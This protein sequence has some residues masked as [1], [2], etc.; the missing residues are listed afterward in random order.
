LNSGIGFIQ[1]YKAEKTISEMKSLLVPHVKVFRDDQLMEIDSTNLVPGDIV[2]VSEGDKLMADCRILHNNEIQANEA[3][4]TG[5]SF[6]Q[7][8]SSETL[9]LELELAN[10]ENMLYMG[11]SIIGGSGKAVVVSTGMQTEFGKIAGLLQEIK[12]EKTPLEKKLDDF[13]KKVAVIVLVLSMIAILIGYLRG[14]KLAEMILTGIALAISV[15][16]EGVPAIIAITLALAIGRMQKHNALIRKLPAA[17]TL[18]RT[19]VICTDKTGTL[20]EEE[21]VVTKLYCGGD[22][23]NVKNNLLY[24]ENKKVDVSDD[25]N[26]KMLLKIGSMCNNAR[27]EK[28]RHGKIIRI[29]GDP[30]EKAILFVADNFN[31]AS[32]DKESRLKEYSFSSKRKLMSIVWEKNQHIIS[33][34]KGAPDIILKK[35]TKEFVDGRTIHLTEKRKEE[36]LRAYENM[37]A[38]ALRVLGFAYKMQNSNFNQESCENGL[39]FVGFEGIMDPP[40]KEVAPAIKECLNAGIAIKMITGDSI[41]TAKAVADQIGLDGGCIEEK[42]LAKLSEEEFNDMV[43]TKTVFARITP[44]TKFKIIKSLRAQGEI[45]AVTGDGVNDVLALK[46]AHISVAMGIRGTD[47]ARDVSD[48]I[49]L[50]DNFNSIVSAVKE[51]R[52]VYDNLKKSIKAHI[53][54]NLSELFI[55]LFALLLAMPLPLMPLAILW[56]NLITD[57]LPSLALA[58]EPADKDIM[59]RKPLNKKETILTGMFGFMLIAGLVSFVVTIGLFA[60]FYQQDLS[61]ARTIALTTAIF[62][63]MFIVLSC[64][65]EKNIWKIGVFSNK[66]LVFSIAFAIG[67][68]LIAIYTPL[69]LVFG[70]ERLSFLEL[71]IIFLAS[72]PLFIIFEI[73]KFWISKKNQLQQFNLKT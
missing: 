13:S 28:D 49:L 8:K 32:D 66:F 7:S 51:G 34:V 24:F 36:L 30:T 9:K 57:S 69:S 33:Y 56:M 65:S 43:R 2:Q 22:Y 1:Q 21:M 39:I 44:E 23:F 59:K 46:Q 58:V 27:I 26:L 54:A 38:G 19:T 61:K 62:C 71:L 20:T 42:E 29:L 73:K 14:E 53:S 35:S 47:V 5:E 11:T 15:I 60:F 17:E 4:L 3:I 41:I 6:P 52:K 48:I 68:Q 50:D 31:I 64:R 10:R 37:A 12:P 67:L 45:V 40:R 18:G 70:F 25:T 16:P 55:V 63:E 72:L